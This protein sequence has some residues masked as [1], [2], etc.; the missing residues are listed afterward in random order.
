MGMYDDIDSIAHYGVKGMKWGVRR[1][2]NYDGSYTQRGVKRFR[3]AE[4]N[5]DSAKAR[6]KSAKTSGDKVGA[7]A[8]KG[9][10]KVAKRKL[11]KSYKQLKKDKLADQGK[12]LYKSG[13]T[14]TSNNKKAVY[15]QLGIVVGSNLV[16]TTLAKSGNVAFASRVGAGLAVG[17]SAVNAAIAVKNAYET[18]RLRAFYA[19]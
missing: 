6:L 10:V 5:Y 15:T 16:S 11:D 12:A 3:E 17:G 13:K 4:K 9:D 1:Y 2:Q 18:K 19:H 7:R 8:A 14:I